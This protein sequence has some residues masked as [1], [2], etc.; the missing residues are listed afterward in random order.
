M[1]TEH[2]WTE[3]RRLTLELLA[4]I[5]QTG[6]G[7]RA[8]ASVYRATTERGLTLYVV[9]AYAT[10]GVLA[11][12]GDELALRAEDATHESEQRAREAAHPIAERLHAQAVETRALWAG[13]RAIAQQ[14]PTRKGQPS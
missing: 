13:T 10:F 11:P 6:G 5:E 7:A 2:R 12:S 8:V 3:G 9:R 1:N 14:T 4:S